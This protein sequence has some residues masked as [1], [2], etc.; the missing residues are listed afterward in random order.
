MYSALSFDSCVYVMSIHSSDAF[1]SSLLTL[2]VAIH[3]PPS[4]TPSDVPTLGLGFLWI[5]QTLPC[6]ADKKGDIY[7]IFI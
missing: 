3:S 7:T 2:G 4:L 1:H 6:I 5:L